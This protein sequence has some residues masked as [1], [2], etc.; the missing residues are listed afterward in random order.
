IPSSSLETLVDAQN[1]LKEVREDAESY[2]MEI[3]TACEKLKDQARKEGFEK[4]YA[5]WVKRIADLEDEIRKV[6]GE[7]EQVVIPIA[8][9]A[10]KKIVGR[11]LELSKSAIV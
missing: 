3:T 5:E 11:E 1:V 8:L 10:A 6:R 2:K 4:G 7:T 9:K